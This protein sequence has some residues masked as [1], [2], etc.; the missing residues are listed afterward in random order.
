MLTFDAVI[1]AAATLTSLVYSP[2]F[3]LRHT[4]FLIAGIGGA[5]PERTTLG[6][7]TFARYAIQVDLQHELDAR[8]PGVSGSGYLALGAS[9]PGQYP[10]YLYGTEVFGLNGALRDRVRDLHCPIF[11]TIS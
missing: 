11:L 4:Y 2:L 10:G 7:V 9:A 3:D 1:N 5:N 6:G 8:E